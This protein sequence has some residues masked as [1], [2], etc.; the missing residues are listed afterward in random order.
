MELFMCKM[1]TELLEFINNP[2]QVN[3][4]KRADAMAYK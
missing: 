2:N 4:F 3:K 1:S